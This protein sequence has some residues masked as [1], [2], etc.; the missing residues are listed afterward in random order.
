[1]TKQEIV[2]EMAEG[3]KVEGSYV[4]NTSLTE[5]ERAEHQEKL[6]TIAIELAD[7]ILNNG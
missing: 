6:N 3:I 1:M 4:N 5:S 2:R 7:C